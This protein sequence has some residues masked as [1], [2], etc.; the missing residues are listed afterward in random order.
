MMIQLLLDHTITVANLQPTLNFQSTLPLHSLQL[1][2]NPGCI[3][4]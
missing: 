3:P 4:S 2:A 1:W